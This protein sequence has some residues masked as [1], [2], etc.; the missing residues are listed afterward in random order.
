MLDKE[1]LRQYLISKNFMGDGNIPDI[2]FD[3]IM[4]TLEKY[5]ESY[6]KITG[7]PFPLKNYDAVY[8]LEEAV[9]KLKNEL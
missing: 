7:N 2:P 5:L 4:T 1:Y 9:T 8:E 3:V 6:E